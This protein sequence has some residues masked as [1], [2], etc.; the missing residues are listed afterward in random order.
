MKHYNVYEK[1]ARTSIK[2]M[3]PAVGN[4]HALYKIRSTHSARGKSRSYARK[5]AQGSKG[6]VSEA[7]TGI[8]II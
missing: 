2:Y 3:T 8:G 1:K 6:K 5:R 4:V 7:S